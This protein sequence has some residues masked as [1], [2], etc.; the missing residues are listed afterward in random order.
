MGRVRRGATAATIAAVLTAWAGPAWATSAP[1]PGAKIDPAV[2]RLVRERMQTPI[3]RGLTTRVRAAASAR[4][5]VQKGIQVAPGATVV[6]GTTAVP[7]V[8]VSFSNTASV[9]YPTSDLQ[10]ELFDGPWPTGT[11]SEYY[12]EISYGNLDVTGTVYNWVSLPQPDTYYE[13]GSGCNG[14]CGSS[15]VGD[16]IRTSLDALDPTVDFGQY[17]NDGPDGVPNSGDDDGYVDF[18]AFVHPEKGGECGG[19]NIWSHRWVLGG[20]GGGWYTT[21]DERS[22]GG[23]G[24]RVYD[25]VIQPALSCNSVD[26]IEI[27][28]FA[29]EFGH[30][31]GLPDWYDTDGSSNG[32]GNWALMA[33][34]SW[35]GNGYTP[36][37]PA[38]MSAWGKVRLGWI[39]PAV[40]ST[41]LAGV[42]VPNAEEYPVALKIPFGEGVSSDEFFLVENRQKIG[43]DTSLRQAGLLVWHVDDAKTSNTAECVDG[44]VNG[45]CGSSHYEMALEQADGNFDLEQRRNRGDTGD[46]FRAGYNDRLSPDTTP[47][48]M[49]YNATDGAAPILSEISASGSVMTL[50]VSFDDPPCTDVDGDGYGSPASA[51][52]AYAS[53]DCDDADAQV[54]PGAAERCNYADDDCDLA[55]DE[56]FPDLGQACSDGVGACA[57]S[58]F[59]LCDGAG[60]ATECTATPGV[61]TDEVCDDE[62]DNDCDGVA[63][64]DDPDCQPTCTDADGDGYAVEGGECGAL[65]C[66]DTRALVNPAAAEVCDDG[67]DNDCSGAADGADPVCAPTCTDAD[68]DGYATEGGECGD[69]DCDDADADVFPGAAERCNGLDDDCDASPAEDEFDGDGDGVM[70]CAGDCDDADA[71]VYPGAVEMC[72]NQVDEDCSGVLDDDC[73]LPLCPTADDPGVD[74]QPWPLVLCGVGPTDGATPW[75]ALLFALPAL[76]VLAWRRRGDP[77]RVRVRSASRRGR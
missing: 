76:G 44:P 18:I 26:M 73:E 12:S 13:G 65:D 50:S 31:F 55:V 7:V 29:H 21:N 64:L 24:V 53:L 72:G 33:S 52:C 58:G 39:D 9:P 36:E 32:A 25:Y 68:A 22:G 23:G 75:D 28:V 46:P 14:L 67:L 2:L 1:A 5:A 59:M 61:P 45:A 70:I 37:S 10:T 38:H 60:D 16:L 30:A 56:D 4:S 57:A 51:L 74:C 15:K 34:G 40:V 77:A 43:F 47:W 49:D 66:D 8:A 20:W 63:D 35:G 69:V 3:E 62:I 42:A 6:S 48:S 54:H 71:G 17:D 11:M 27:G 19:S 41:S